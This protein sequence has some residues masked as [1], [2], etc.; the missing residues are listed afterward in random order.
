MTFGHQ[1]RVLALLLWCTTVALSTGGKTVIIDP[2]SMD[3]EL[4]ACNRTAQC[5]DD[6]YCDADPKDSSD[7]FVCLHKNLLPSPSTRD[8]LGSITM[9]CGMALAATAGIGGGG[10]NV[11][12]LLL[13]FNFEVWFPR[14]RIMIYTARIN[15]WP[16]TLTTRRN[17]VR[18]FD[19]STKKWLI[20]NVARSTRRSCSRT[21]P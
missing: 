17:R 15:G 21:R 11:P 20:F 10:L 8:A 12:V 3:S 18:A 1:R 7:K 16:Y 6:R 5:A 9:L 2:S 4:P 13:V 14:P 19:S